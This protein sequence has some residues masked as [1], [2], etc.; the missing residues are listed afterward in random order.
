MYANAC[1]ISDLQPNGGKTKD[2]IEAG[3]AVA[4]TDRG[5]KNRSSFHQS[6]QHR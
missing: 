2:V 4:R 5:S 6:R 1:Q 3:I